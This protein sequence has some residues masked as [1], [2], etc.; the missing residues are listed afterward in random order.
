MNEKDFSKENPIVV[1]LFFQYGMILQ[2]KEV[3]DFSPSLAGKMAMNTTIMTVEEIAE[4]LNELFKVS[5][6]EE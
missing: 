3:Q 5:Q 6:Q 2:K 1:N 4:K